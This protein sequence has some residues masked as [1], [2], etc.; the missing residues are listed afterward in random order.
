MAMFDSSIVSLIGLQEEWYL[1]LYQ[2]LSLSS[3]V[4][5]YCTHATRIRTCCDLRSIAT[6][7]QLSTAT[8]IQHV[9]S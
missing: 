4:I 1:V 8:G 6:T 5:R 2:G 7:L 9:M 3:L